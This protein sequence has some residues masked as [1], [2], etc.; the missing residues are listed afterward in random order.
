MPWLALAASG[1]PIE[2]LFDVSRDP[3]DTV[4]MSPQES[5]TAC[6][7]LLCSTL[8]CM[9]LTSS[10]GAGG[11]RRVSRVRARETV[12]SLPLRCRRKFLRYFPGGFRDATYVDWE[13]GYKWAAH[14][15]WLAQLDRERYRSLL[16]SGEYR[17]IA[18]RAI[19]I[20][21]RTNLLFSFEKMALRDAVREETPAQTFAEGLF[22]FL[23]GD[24]HA[25][26]RFERWR[27][28]VAALPVRQTRVLTWPLL[29]VFGFIARPERH[30]F[31]KPSVT[32][33]AAERYGF[34][35]H[36]QP[37]PQWE[38][39]AS[40]LTFG[41]RVLEEQ[42]GLKPRD[43]IDAQSFIWVQGSDEYPGR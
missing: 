26:V 18:R 2:T 20:E 13:R 25:R 7:R 19:A 12:T 10:A 29:T 27:D 40:V 37:A 9:A 5:S 41:R 22:S 23:Y 17:E 30:M 34:D 42:S 11:D 8:S 3:A 4:K 28:T 35:L 31:L 15:E 38:T 39:Y 43:M 36:Y 16:N 33:R 21:S 14:T 6:R 32:K 1:N 24:G